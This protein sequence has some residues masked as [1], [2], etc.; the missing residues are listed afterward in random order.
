M[1]ITGQ[2]ARI[3]F[4]DY[5]GDTLA[6]RIAYADITGNINL[7]GS[8]V[9]AEIID[10]ATF[11]PL[12]TY[13]TTAGTITTSG[14]DYNIIFDITAAQTAQLGAANYL[15]HIKV[16]DSLG[17]VNTLISG[18]LTLKKQGVL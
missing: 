16:I 6:V 5:A 13:S 4:E 14:T 12:L 15:Y 17:S 3:D 10:P 8:T 7:A 1:K 18:I 11:I 9:T 2:T